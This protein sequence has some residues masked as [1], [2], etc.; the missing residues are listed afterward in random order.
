VN[1]LALV[2][3]VL[4]I[5]MTA[6]AEDPLPAQTIVVFNSTLPESTALAKFY[7][8]KR[9]VARDHL[10]ALECSSEEEISREE[11]ETTIAEPLR[12]AFQKRNWWQLSD[13][14]NGGERVQSIAIRFVALVKGVPLKIKA[15]EQ[16]LPGD[17]PGP[18]PVQNRNEA[19]VDS[20]L[21]TLAFFAK[22][23]SGALN[24]PYFQSYRPIAEFADA[25]LLLVCRL[26]APDAETVRQMI[27]DAIETQQNGLWGRAY[28][29]GAHNTVGK[30]AVGDTWLSTIVQQFHKAGVPVVYEDTPDTF[31]NEYPLSDCAL[32]YGWYTNDVTGPFNQPD[33]KLARG[34]V[35]VHIHSF[36]AATLRNLNGHWAGPLLVRGAAATIGNV[37]EPYLQLTAQLDILN[38]RLLH[39]FTFAESVYMSTRVLSWMSVAIGDPLY[40]P[41]VNWTQLDPRTPITKAAADWREY[42]EFA[43]KNS[44]LPSADYRAQARNVAARTHNALMMEDIALMDLNSG[45]FTAAISGLQVARATYTKRDDILRCVLEEC[46]AWAKSGKPHRALDLARNT[47]QITP[48]APA[49]ELLRKM[50]TKFAPPPAALRPSTSPR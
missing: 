42:H 3:V 50:K 36:S 44:G 40:R 31:A 33:F 28:V 35:A 21:S 11:Y 6:H 32:Y 10:V 48:H 4:L 39:G 8:E 34:A 19:A 14:T 5:R 26:D 13:T 41:F 9:G 22:E 1:R 29:D 30:F 24:N 18:G 16:T 7:A 49:S 38:D 37:Y 47:L 27:I 23:I 12:A 43:V 15:T 46:D 20:E 17:N 2:L 45:N 25:P